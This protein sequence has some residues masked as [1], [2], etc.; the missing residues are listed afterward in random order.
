MMV[1][2]PPKE[3]AYD[4]L[5]QVALMGLEVFTFSRAYFQNQP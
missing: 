5:V 3:T 1:I 2:A 4:I